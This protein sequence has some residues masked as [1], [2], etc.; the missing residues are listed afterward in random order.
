MGNWLNW[1]MVG[2]MDGWMDGWLS[3]I[4]EK[5]RNGPRAY[6]YNSIIF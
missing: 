2:R 3:Q 6:D 5:V 1:W 4:A